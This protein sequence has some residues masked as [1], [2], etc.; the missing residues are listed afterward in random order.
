MISEFDEALGL[1]PVDERG[2]LAFADPWYE[3][4]NA[5]FGGPTA[6]VAAEPARHR[7]TLRAHV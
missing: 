2:W 6:A 1:K 3:S 4:V 5:T 7:S